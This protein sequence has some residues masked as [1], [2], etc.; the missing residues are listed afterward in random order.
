MPH[1][2]RGPHNELLLEQPDQLLL[3]ADVAPDPPVRA[4]EEAGD[5]R[6]FV[7]RGQGDS[8]TAKIFTRERTFRATRVVAHSTQL[9]VSSHQERAQVVGQRE[10][11]CRAWCDERNVLV[12]SG[13][14]LQHC[15]GPASL[16]LTGYCD[17]HAS[18]R[19]AR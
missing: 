13:F 11:P 15:G 7:Q 19:N 4:V 12:N 6:L 2:F 18:D 17:K 14:D 5:S 9:G 1:G 8:E 16:P 3:N 10:V